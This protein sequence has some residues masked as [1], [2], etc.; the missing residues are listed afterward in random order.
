MA[1]ACDAA[2]NIYVW[3][4]GNRKIRCIN[5]NRDVVTITGGPSSNTDGQNPSFI[6]VSQMCVDGSGNLILA[7]GSS[8]RKM[9]SLQKS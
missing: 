3:D 6:S 8:I 2:D 9:E 4:S 7:C 1:L 5:Q